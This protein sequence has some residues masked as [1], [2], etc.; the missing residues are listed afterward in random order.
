MIGWRAPEALARGLA[1]LELWQ[2]CKEP[3]IRSRAPEAL[4]KG[5]EH[6]HPGTLSKSS[7]LICRASEPMVG[8][9]APEVLARGFAA[10]EAAHAGG[11]ARCGIAHMD[12]LTAYSDAGC[13]LAV[14][15]CGTYEVRK[16]LQDCRAD[17]EASRIFMTVVAHINDLTAYS[18]SGCLLTID[19]CGTY[20]VRIDRGTPPL[21]RRRLGASRQNQRQSG[22]RAAGSARVLPIPVGAPASAQA[23]RG[24]AAA[25]PAILRRGVRN[26]W[27]HG[28]LA[29]LVIGKDR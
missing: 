26:P 2:T 22:R 29:R 7:L 12:D 15:C 3:M 5:L 10:L 25:S 19:C 18:D 14:D 21:L 8:S 9:R 20:E 6:T 28:N 24:V 1:A 4:G 23:T 17:R 27:L 16:E 11:R 13:L